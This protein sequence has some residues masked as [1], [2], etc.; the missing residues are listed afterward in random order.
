[1]ARATKY[2]FITDVHTAA[3]LFEL[4]ESTVGAWREGSMWTHDVQ[5][6]SLLAWA[7]TQAG[8]PKQR[9]QTEGRKQKQD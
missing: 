2:H 7:M 5:G 1:M 4:H 6:A 9:K 8:T 3:A